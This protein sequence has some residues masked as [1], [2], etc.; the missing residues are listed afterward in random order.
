MSV[1]MNPGLVYSQKVS[2]T[3]CRA[4]ISTTIRLATEPSRVRFPARVDVVA[5]VSQPVG[6]KDARS[7]ISATTPLER[8][9]S[10]CLAA[11]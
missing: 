2:L 8:S 1:M 7:L 6:W 9:R 3:L 5:K 4:A 10:N 11:Q